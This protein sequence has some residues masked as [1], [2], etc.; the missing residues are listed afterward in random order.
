MEG[1]NSSILDRP[2]ELGLGLSSGN[3][4]R[5]PVADDVTKIMLERLVGWRRPLN[6][7]GAAACA[8]L[9]VL[10]YY[11]QFAHGMEPCPLCVFQRIGFFVLGGAFLIAGLHAPSRCGARVYAVALLAIAAVGSGL[12]GR[13]VWI[14]SLPPD[15]VPACG[16]GLD[17]L[18]DTLSVGEAMRMVLQGSG[19]CA[20]VDRLLGI[21]LPAWSLAGFVALGM[22]GA[23]VNWVRPRLHPSGPRR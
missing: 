7:V 20:Q 8:A 3:M 6:L 16:P 23:L 22:A 17:Y 18:F 5:L 1:G 15:Q 11:L 9:L 12:A 4:A 14:Q 2:L 13:H 19:E 10:A 21:S